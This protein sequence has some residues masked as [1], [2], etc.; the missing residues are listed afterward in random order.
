MGVGAFILFDN[1]TMHLSHDTKILVKKQINI[2][3]K[4]V[5]QT[6]MIKLLVVTLNPRIVKY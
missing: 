5:I 2:N 3:I 6:V 1:R 4:H